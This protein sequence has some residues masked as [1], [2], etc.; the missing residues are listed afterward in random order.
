MAFANVEWRKLHEHAVFLVEVA[1]GSD[2]NP[3]LLNNLPPRNKVGKPFKFESFNGWGMQKVCK[4]L[5]GCKENLKV[6]SHSKFGNLSI[7]IAAIKDQLLDIQKC[8]EQGFNPDSNLFSQCVGSVKY[9]IN[10]N[11]GQVCVVSPGRGLRQGNPLSP[12]LFL[13]VADVFSNLLNKVVEKKS[14]GGIRMKKRCHVVSHLFFANDSLIFLEADL[15]FCSNFMDIMGCFGEASSLS[16][17]ANKS[18]VVFSH[19]TK[20]EVKEEIKRILGMEKMKGTKKYLGLPSFWGKSKKESLSYLR[21]KI[22][23]KTQGWGNKDL[24]HAGK[25]VL[26]KSILQPIPM[27]IFM[28]IKGLLEAVRG[29]SPSWIW[30]SQLEGKKLIQEGIQWNM[31]SGELIRFWDDAWI[32]DLLGAKVS[33]GSAIRGDYLKVVDFIDKPSN[34][35]NIEKLRNCISEVEVQVICKIPVSIS[36]AMDKLI[37]RH[38]NLGNY[39]VKSGYHQW[40]KKASKVNANSPSSSFTPFSDMWSLFWRVSSAPKVLMFMWKARNNFV[41]RGKTPNPEEVIEQA[42]KG[43]SDYLS[44]IF[45][46]RSKAPTKVAQVE[47]WLAP[48]PSTFKINC[49]GAYKSS[50]SLAAFGIIAR[51]HGGL[52]QVWRC[53]RV[54]VSPVLAIETWTLRIACSLLMEYNYPSVIF[55]LDCKNLIDSISELSS[56][57][58]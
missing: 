47:K 31:G 55:K 23:R 33:Q 17:N 9:Y 34:S 8:L 41:F 58:F 21:D 20:I 32:P 11:G 18:S 54:K 12:Y 22:V 27:F 45:S 48:P 36:K 1:I 26:I 30:C 16:L 25:E 37:W 4:K 19:N 46:S 42:S 38:T 3:L 28:C 39:S 14:L 5:R 53:G 2:H 15:N 13:L 7:K 52:A 51:D 10:A 50:S 57:T 24:N 29:S 44:A 56:T 49:D 40:V 43:N 35:W 6:W